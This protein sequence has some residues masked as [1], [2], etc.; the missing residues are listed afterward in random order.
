[1]R[2][3]TIVFVAVIIIL[4]ASAV[5]CGKNNKNNKNENSMNDN[6]KPESS[7]TETSS[8]LKYI[9]LK[10]G[11]GT[12]AENGLAVKVHYTL[13][14]DS[15]GDKGGMIDSSL[16][17]EPRPFPFTVGMD[18]LIAGWNEGMLGMQVGGLRKLYIPSALG[19]G[20]SGSPPIISGNSNLIFEIELLE[21]L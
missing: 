5:I 1:M 3:S 9:D 2:Q 18:G 4:A 21:I 19:Y 11:E 13:W 16:E 12:K 17:P 7:V 20:D 6:A 8:G 10:V 14:L 15:G